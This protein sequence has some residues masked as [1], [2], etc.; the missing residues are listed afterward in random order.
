MDKVYNVVGYVKLAK[1]WERSEES[2][3]AYHHNYYENKFADQ[4]IYK[5]YDVY[6]DITGKK[7]IYK[8]MEMVRLLKDCQ[9]GR[10]DIIFTQTKAYLAANTGEFCYLLKF[11][12]SMNH[13][14][15]IITEDD[16]Y[17]IN[18][19]TNED[20]QREALLKMADDFIDLNPP[21]FQEWLNELVKSINSL[22]I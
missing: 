16:A 18:T 1:L 22:D 21:D 17:N 5:L 20:G 15:D 6:I 4:P 11:L 9:F 8:R 12:F 13:R 10:V 19:I 2:A 3:I 14:I 7:E